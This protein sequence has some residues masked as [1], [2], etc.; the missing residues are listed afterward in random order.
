M[1]FV[2]LSI[3]IWINKQV[4]TFFLGFIAFPI[5]IGGIFY[6]KGWDKE[7]ADYIELKKRINISIEMVENGATKEELIK[8]LKGE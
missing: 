2:L 4:L 3:G 1:L 8:V 6:V 7:E 5:L